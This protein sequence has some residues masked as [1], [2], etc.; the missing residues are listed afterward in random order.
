MGSSRN[1]HS[2]RIKAYMIVVAGGLGLLLIIIVIGVF[3]SEKTVSSAPVN[4]EVTDQK[5]QIGELKSGRFEA[6]GLNPENVTQDDSVNKDSVNKHATREAAKAFIS[7]A[8][9]ANLK[10]ELSISAEEV[11]DQIAR[12]RSEGEKAIAD[13][14]EQQL[15]LLC[16]MLQLSAYSQDIVDVN[17]TYGEEKLEKYCNGYPYGTE[18]LNNIQNGL[19]SAFSAFSDK[20]TEKMGINLEPGKFDRA[21]LELIVDAS[22]PLE[23]DAI[24]A[25]IDAYRETGGAELVSLVGADSLMMRDAALNWGDALTIYSC[26][27]FGNCHA[28]SP[29]FLFYC[30]ILRNDCARYS[31]VLDFLYD[32][33][34]PIE[35]ESVNFLLGEINKFEADRK[36]SG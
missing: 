15:N 34:S 31:N 4:T 7:A 2:S 28:R 26:Q 29:R 32:R 13:L 12:Y 3:N 25:E 8:A 19:E 33:L 9:T 16:G 24:Q 22:S 5:N 18:D 14:L 23:I 21:L 17:M 30:F 27:K 1:F 11:L 10:F 36:R 6:R 20:F 35:V